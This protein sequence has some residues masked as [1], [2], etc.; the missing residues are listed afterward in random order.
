MAIRPG[1]NKVKSKDYF[2][3]K[4]EYV[5]SKEYNIHQNRLKRNNKYLMFGFAFSSLI[6]FVFLNQ[7]SIVMR[8]FKGDHDDYKGDIKKI[9]KRLIS[10]E[11]DVIIDTSKDIN[12]TNN[13][14]GNIS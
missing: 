9:E 14:S 8:L 2:N 1:S 13:K 6:I 5:K 12:K 10:K 11:E 7:K 4:Q 3:F